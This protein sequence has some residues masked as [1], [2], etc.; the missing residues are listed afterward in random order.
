[1]T[2]Y[3]GKTKNKNIPKDREKIKS[4][5]LTKAFQLV[6]ICKKPFGDIFSGTKFL[7]WKPSPYFAAIY[8]TN[9]MN[10]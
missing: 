2:L 6:V 10:H 1:M 4:D 5:A 7:G 3:S 8:G 9:G